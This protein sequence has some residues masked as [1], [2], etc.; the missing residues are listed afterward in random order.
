MISSAD[1][2][3]AYNDLYAQMRKY[4]WGY[5]TVEAL[6]DLEIATYLR[7]PELSDIRRYFN[8][9]M[10]LTRDVQIKDEELTTAFDKFQELIDQDDMIFNKLYSVDEVVQE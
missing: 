2:Q 5:E 7:C 10:M 4:I 6:A 1:I 8:I 9:L 3:Y